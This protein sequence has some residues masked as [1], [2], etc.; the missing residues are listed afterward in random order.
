MVFS[1]LNRLMKHRLNATLLILGGALCLCIDVGMALEQVVDYDSMELS[2]SLRNQHQARFSLRITEAPFV[3]NE[4]SVK[5]DYWGTDDGAPTTVVG[6]LE[7]QI[8]KNSIRIFKKAYADLGNPIIPDGIYL[9]E[10]GNTVILNLRGGDGAGGYHSRLF[11]KDLRLIRRKTFA[12]STLNSNP[13]V[14]H[15]QEEENQK[16]ENPAPSDVS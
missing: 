9:M 7:L 2:G 12:G 10:D 8:G 14:L 1:Q 16:Q 4:A 11:F 15:F 3:A 5:A 6:E 13:E